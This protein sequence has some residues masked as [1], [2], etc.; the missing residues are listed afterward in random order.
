MSKGHES[1]DLELA[2][3][4]P[5]PDK[6]QNQDNLRRS[7]PSNGLGVCGK[8]FSDVSYIGRV[9]S[10]AL[11]SHRKDK[12]KG[13]AKMANITN[14]NILDFQDPGTLPQELMDVPGFINELTDYTLAE[15]HS[16]NRMLAFFGAT[17]MLAHLAGR[18]YTDVH[19]TRTNIYL[20]ALGETGIGKDAPRRTNGKLL[21]LVGSTQSHVES[22]ASGEALEEF[23]AKHPVALYQPDEVES[24]I[25]KMCTTGKNAIG[26]SE[27]IRR[28]YSASAGFYTVRSTARIPEGTIV[29][30]PHLT[31]FGTGTPQAF[32]DALD[33]RAIMNGLFGRCLVVN[34][35]DEYR[36]NLPTGMPLPVNIVDQARAFVARENE[37]C[38]SG[39]LNLVTV[40]ESPDAN[41]AFRQ[42]A[43][44]LMLL[45]KRLSDSELF[46]ARALVVRMNE[47]IA[48][49]A[50]I[51]AISANPFEPIVTS[52]AVTWAAKFVTHITKAMLHEAQ[53]HVAEGKFDALV[54][55]AI[56][57]LERKGGSVDRSSLLR[58][59]HTDA[60]TL[61]RLVSTLLMSE[62]IE[63]EV[64]SG[65]K[66]IYSLRSA[67]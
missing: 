40:D 26:L 36:T 51:Y 50:M 21:D 16:P 48:K 43:D 37:V 56:S 29:P 5:N 3:I 57:Y 25:G 59:L 30:Y 33:S 35:P 17:A 20:V 46:T 62:V 8:C 7:V 2:E 11:L 9:L 39:Q 47:K 61:K 4:E 52:E 10:V 58:Y 41:M 63:D 64:I 53:F 13:K 31:I 32:Y 24:F 67:A 34:V 55:R 49:L 19:G 15:S 28:L 23:V 54:K 66:V 12:Q 18:S 45:R 1:K 38:Q 42:S 22:L 27:R 6:K 65:G 14:N 44:T 60:V